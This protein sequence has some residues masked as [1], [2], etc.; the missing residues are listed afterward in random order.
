MIK[1]IKQPGLK[2]WDLGELPGTPQTKETQSKLD[3]QLIKTPDQSAGKTGES[4]VEFSNRVLKTIKD[5]IEI[6]PANACVVTHNSVFG[7]I[8]LWNS[9]GRPKYLDRPFRTEYTNQGSDTGDHFVIKGKNGDIYICRHGETQDNADGNF[10]SDDVDLTVKG[11]QEAKDLGKDLSEV[12]I[13][14]ITSSPLP[15]AIETSEAIIAGQAKEDSKEEQ[16]DEPKDEE[17]ED[18]EE[19]ESKGL[20]KSVFLYMEPR[21]GDDEKTFASCAGC[22]MFLKKQQLCSLHG[23]DLKV[24]EDDSCGLFVRG[25]A[26][27][28]EIDH[29][30]ASVTV[31]ESGFME[32]PVQ[33]QNCHYYYSEKDGADCL[34]FR[35]LGIKDYKVPPHACCNAFS[36]KHKP[37]EESANEKDEK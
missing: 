35:M 10:R 7:L 24:D 5:I 19:E 29:L 30:E 12:E 22:R 4:F 11:K 16:Q 3:D 23:P 33:C 31:E 17:K 9:K 36:P 34:L 14:E 32:G 26:P 37:K 15:R 20:C 18:M 21:K 28:D 1:I 8:K 6:A 27:S 2:T 25:K 13:S